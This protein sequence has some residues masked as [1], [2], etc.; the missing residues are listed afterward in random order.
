[1]I[2]S[3]SKGG[4]Q[5]KPELPGVSEFQQAKKGVISSVRREICFFPNFS[6]NLHLMW[7]R[8]SSPVLLGFINKAWLLSSCCI[9]LQRWL[10]V[11]G[12]ED[13]LHLQLIK[14]FI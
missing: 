5:V 7:S 10:H 9:L 6:F 3:L 11:C 8:V 1:M 4:T 14:S 2:F 13:D 12:E